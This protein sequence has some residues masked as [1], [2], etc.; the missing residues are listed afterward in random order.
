MV[1][2]REVREAAAVLRRLLD[3]VDGG[4]VMAEGPVGAGVVRQVRGAIVAL[5]AVA[6]T[7]VDRRETD[8]QARG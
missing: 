7:T 4:Q 6:M 5:D 8:A 2:T 3:A 1:T